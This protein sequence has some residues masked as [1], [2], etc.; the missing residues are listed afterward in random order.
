MN[1]KVVVT[2]GSGFIGR[3]TLPLL[4][5]LGFE[6]YLI[7]SKDEQQQDLHV[8]WIKLNLF[9]YAQVEK[10]IEAIKPAY[11]LHLAWYTE[12]G[13]FWNG[14]ENLDWLQA[15]LHLIQQ[16]HRHG[17]KRVVSAGS[18]AEY[19][20]NFS[21]YSE[22]T[23]PYQ[24][25]TLYGTSKRALYSILQKFS[26]QV[27]LS[28]AWGYLFYLFGPHEHPKRFFSSVIQAIL[29]KE[30]L[31]CSHGN[32]IRDFLYVKDV[33][34]AF[35]LL[36]MSDFEGAINIGSGKGISLKEAGLAVCQ[37]LNGEEYLKFGAL[38]AP[39]HD[40]PK[41]I[42]DIS[43]LTQL[44]WAP[45]YEFQSGLKETIAWWNL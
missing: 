34:R 36:L 13:K 43:L 5:Q 40:P 41:L 15:S 7:S 45:K 11:L 28:F 10:V 1:K 30:P 16:F 12:P 38:E 29:K 3:H 14:L 26:K 22:T 18:C 24:P 21:L 42:A 44:N 4:T 17:G 31:A 2:G 9:D 39:P 19:D 20:W 37:I 32:Q 25:A 35:V 33:A 23:T 6:V 8:K 27:G